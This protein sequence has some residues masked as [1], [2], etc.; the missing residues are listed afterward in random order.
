MAFH[1][2]QTDYSQNSQTEIDLDLR[3]IDSANGE[4]KSLASFRKRF[5]DVTL[6]GLA[7]MFTLPILL[8]VALIIKL[9]DGGNIFFVQERIGVGGKVFKCYKFRSMV[10]NAQEL[11]LIHI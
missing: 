1:S 4:H 10:T 7:L 6:A 9:Q 8:G 5:F 11:S 2:G 3:P